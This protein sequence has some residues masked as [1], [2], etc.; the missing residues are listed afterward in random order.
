VDFFGNTEWPGSSSDL[1]ACENLGSI[2]KDR[3]EQRINSTNEDLEPALARAL[4]D[5]KFDTELFLP[6]LESYPARLEAVR[7]ARGG[8]TRY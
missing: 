3:V 1:N 6:L 4:G 2:L 8:H 7:K 5:L